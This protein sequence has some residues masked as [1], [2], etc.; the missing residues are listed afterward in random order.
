M[1]PDYIYSFK[2]IVSKKYI[3]VAF[4]MN[5]NLYYYMVQ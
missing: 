3:C 4:E 1:I 5:N 2:M